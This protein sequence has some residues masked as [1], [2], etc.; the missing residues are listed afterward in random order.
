MNTDITLHGTLAERW[1]SDVQ[2]Q[3]DLK[4]ASVAWLIRN[5]RVEISPAASAGAAYRCD[6]RAT[7]GN[8][9]VLDVAVENSFVNGCVADAAARLRREIGRE[10]RFGSARRMGGA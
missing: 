1:R 9:L 7:L 3:L 10:Q 4:L 5:L 8:A 2:R 6:I